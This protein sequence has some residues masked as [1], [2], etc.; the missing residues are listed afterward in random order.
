M[1]GLFSS[2]S[3]QLLGNFL[4]S[5]GLPAVAFVLGFQALIAPR[6]P[7]TW[8]LLEAPE[9]LE[10]EWKTAFAA[11]AV[12]AF[13]T[14]LAALN[15]PLIRLYEGYPLRGSWIGRRM[16]ERHSRRAREAEVWLHG[17]RSILRGLDRLAKTDP[18]RAASIREAGGADLRERWQAIRQQQARIYPES[19]R[20]LPTRLGNVIR[21]FEDYPKAKYGIYGV[22]VWPR[23]SALIEDGYAKRINDAKQPFDLLLNFSVVSALLGGLTLLGGLLWPARWMPSA[24]GAAV[25]AVTVAALLALGR[26]WYLVALPRAA[27]WGD[28]VKS[29]YDLYRWDLLEKLG[30]SRRPADGEEERELWRRIGGHML[31]GRLSTSPRLEYRPEPEPPETDPRWLR[32]LRELIS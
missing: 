18:A 28:T 21:A 19:G 3:K 9:A 30:F 6:L 25:W 12:A 8:H 29:A 10:A 32:V 16:I 23:L 22:T 20:A 1:G 14:A 27:V 13:A 7:E 2:L 4:Y 11:L 15:G 31:F 24:T 5:S 26:A 17:A